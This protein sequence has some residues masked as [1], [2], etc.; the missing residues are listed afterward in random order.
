MKQVRG[1]D[2]WRRDN[3]E[4]GTDNGET[5]KA[6]EAKV[7]AWWERGMIPFPYC[8]LVSVAGCT[9]NRCANR[10]DVVK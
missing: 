7:E 1:C 3:D 6:V 4:D 2:E 8:S 5:A 9:D 10:V